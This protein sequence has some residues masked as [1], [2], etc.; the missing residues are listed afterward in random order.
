MRSTRMW[1]PILLCILVANTARGL[2]RGPE[3]REVPIDRLLKNLQVRLE[4]NT[5]DFEAIYYLARAQSM[6]YAYVKG[7]VGIS[8]R[9]DG[10]P[11]YLH[12]PFDRGIPDSVQN[13]DTDN[14]RKLARQHLTNAI[15]LFQ[16]A[17]VLLKE[18]T[19]I[20][21]RAWTMLPV[22]LG[23]AWCLDQAG[24]TNDAISMYRKTLDAAWKIEVTCDFDFK[25]WVT[26]SWENVQAT[27]YPPGTNKY[28]C[29]GEICYSQEIIGYLLRLLDSAKDKEE[30]G[31][32][33]FEKW[34]LSTMERAISPIL[35]PLEANAGF[36]E[37]VDKNAR[38]AFDLDGSRFKRKWAW[39][40]PKAGWLVFDPERTGCVE[41]A[42]QMFGNVTF[43]IFWSNGYEALSALD[44]NADGLLSGPELRGLAIW[45]D[46]NC[47]GVSD[48][49]EVTP[50]EDLG[51]EVIS[52]R[53]QVDAKGM[54]WNPA[55]VIFANGTF[56][57][58]Y[59]WI[60]PSSE[61][62][63]QRF[64]TISHD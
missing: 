58:S 32:L 12:S 18:S 16:R 10:M 41:S 25:Q 54:H 37:L 19:N 20:N 13:F 46:R 49:G 23:L 63:E 43:W 30:I 38:V 39:L 17:L 31:H 11:L 45:N 57:A 35:I 33:K 55:G 2:Y 60:V 24:R 36:D 6:A 40:T 52:C 64:L 22:P 8:V 59:D 4:R 5:N 21:K 28:S 50:V 7:S 1:V 3:I 62:T 51:I 48:P 26:N 14:D 47:D 56:R 61:A 44:D 9:E 27:A 29:I 42:L 53:S 34:K 15:T